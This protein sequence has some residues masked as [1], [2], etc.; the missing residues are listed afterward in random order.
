MTITELTTD[1][2]GNGIIEKIV[3]KH[4]QID[5]AI[6]WA[7]AYAKKNWDTFVYRQDGTEKYLVNPTTGDCLVFNQA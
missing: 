3:Y 2:T 5:K 4:K 7:E 6:E 1:R